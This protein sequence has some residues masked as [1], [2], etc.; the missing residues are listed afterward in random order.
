MKKFIKYSYFYNK[1]DNNFIFCNDLYKSVYYFQTILSY[2]M[3]GNYIIFAC[4]TYFDDYANYSSFSA[5]NISYKDLIAHYKEFMKTFIY[6]DL[7]Y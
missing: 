7:N 4:P 1:L 2:K 5:N 3:H 6:R